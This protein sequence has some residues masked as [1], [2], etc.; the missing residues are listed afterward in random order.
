MSTIPGESREYRRA[1]NELLEREA[2]LRQLNELVAAQHR[3][4]PPSGLIKEDYIFE[5]AADGSKVK[6]S[7]LFK[8]GKNC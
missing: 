5:S 6:I 7:E 8:P 4:L 3:A 1:R 2:E